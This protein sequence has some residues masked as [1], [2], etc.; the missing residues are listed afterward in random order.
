MAETPINTKVQKEA[1]KKSTWEATIDFFAHILNLK[2]GLDRKGTVEKIHKNIETKGANIWLLISAIFIASIGLDT[3]SPAVIIGAMLISPLM[4]PILG[5]GLSIGINDKKTLWLS[6]RHFSVA[7]VVSLI[8]SVIYF[9]ISP[10][11]SLTSE[12]AGRI[13]PTFLDVMVAFFGGI[14]GVVAITRKD[15]INAVP[16]VAI[17]TALLPPLCVTGFGLANWDLDVAWGSFYLFFLNSTFVSLATYIIVRL[18]KFPHR[19]YVN[20]VERQRSAIIM[21]ISAIVLIIPSLFQMT[22]ILEKIKQDNELKNYVT[23]VFEKDNIELIDWNLEKTDSISLLNVTIVPD[24]YIP[25]DSLQKFKDKFKEHKF[26]HNCDLKI[27][28]LKDPPKNTDAVTLQIKQLEDEVTNIKSKQEKQI[29]DLETSLNVLKRDSI[30]Y[31]ELQDELKALFPEL[32]KFG[33]SKTIEA[34]FDTELDTLNVLLLNWSEEA[35][36]DKK[37]VKE[38]LEKEERLKAFMEAKLDKGLFKIIRY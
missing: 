4:S 2:D 8:T 10:F 28:Q 22:K 1:P 17:A 15:L 38:L 29:L 14:A 31:G 21:V 25:K 30:P 33:I 13:S 16:G 12:I 5:I 27:L 9:S 11:G 23:E 36:K 6:V 19:T 20:K 26:A 34:K 7:I 3:N 37:K 35:T 32:M 18:L 24:K